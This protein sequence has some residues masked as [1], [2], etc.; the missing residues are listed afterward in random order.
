[1]IP[2]IALSEAFLRPMQTPQTISTE[3]TAAQIRLGRHVL[4]SAPTNIPHTVEKPYYSATM[5]NGAVTT[6][7]LP[8]HLAANKTV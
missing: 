1:M 8:T 5:A 3:D 2:N 4:I 7:A 6:T